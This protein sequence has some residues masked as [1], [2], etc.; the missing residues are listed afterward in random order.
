M[1]IVKVAA[2]DLAE[3]DEL[4]RYGVVGDIELTKSGAVVVHAT[5]RTLTL[6]ADT[7]VPVYRG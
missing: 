6:A 1:R 5:W 4:P 2:D 7:A 3:G